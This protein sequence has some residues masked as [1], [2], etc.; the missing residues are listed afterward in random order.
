MGFAGKITQPSPKTSELIIYIS[1]KLKDK[2]N[3]GSTLLG[4]SLCLIDSMSF[5]KTGHAITDFSYVKQ[6]RGPTPN[7][8][9]FLPIRDALVESGDLEKLN[10]Q[11]FGRTQNKYVAKRAPKIEVF[12]KD[13]IYLIDDV[14]ESICDHNATEISNLSHQFIAWI[15]AKDKEEL[16]FYTFLLSHTDPDTK[17]LVWANKSIKAYK[18]SN[19][20]AS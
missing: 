2:P 7:P 10:A 14:L 20:N 8:R 1:S 3:Y 9:Q 17:D 13:E 5:L 12:D 6:E 11:Y 19:K 15:F 18:A 4:K 16:P